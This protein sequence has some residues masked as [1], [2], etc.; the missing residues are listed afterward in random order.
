MIGV[1]PPAA[2]DGRFAPAAFL[3]LSASA[4]LF[5]SPIRR[6]KQAGAKSDKVFPS[7]HIYTKNLGV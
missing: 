4:P 6:P 1:L 5:R 3:R 2:R 7:V